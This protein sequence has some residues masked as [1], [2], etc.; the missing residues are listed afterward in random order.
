MSTVQTERREELRTIL[1][2][3]KIEV[4]AALTNLEEYDEEHFAEV[5]TAAKGL[6]EFFPQ[7]GRNG[8][9]Y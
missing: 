6:V 8:R 2:R 5:E 4:N 1:E 9:C 7:N 3:A